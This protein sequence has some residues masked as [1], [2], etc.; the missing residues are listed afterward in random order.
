MLL[1]EQL[2]LA[3]TAGMVADCKGKNKQNSLKCWDRQKKPDAERLFQQ[4]Y[5]QL[6]LFHHQLKQ[7]LLYLEAHMNV[8]QGVPHFARQSI[9]RGASSSSS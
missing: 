9:P 4:G 1:T 6:E 5:Q 7:Q 3:E 2:P 8:N